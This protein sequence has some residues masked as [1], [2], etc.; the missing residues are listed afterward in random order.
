MDDDTYLPPQRIHFTWQLKKSTFCSLE[1]L[2]KIPTLKHTIIGDKEAP[3]HLSVAKGVSRSCDCVLHGWERDT[4]NSLRNRNN[5]YCHRV[6]SY[7]EA[8]IERRNLALDHN[9]ILL[10]SEKAQIPAT[11]DRSR[12]SSSPEATSSLT[13]CSMKSLVVKN[14]VEEAENMIPPNLPT[15]STTVSLPI[16]ISGTE[17]LHPTSFSP[18]ICIRYSLQVHFQA[19]FRE[20]ANTKVRGKR[21][22]GG[23]HRHSNSHYTAQTDLEV[24]I[25]IIYEGE[26]EDTDENHEINELVFAGEHDETD[27]IVVHNDEQ[28][29]QAI[30]EL[31]P[32]Y[33][34]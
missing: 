17:L 25:Q 13:G 30:E 3:V 33:S 5:N 12:T 28:L 32:G 18:Y 31:L 1:P 14:K 29:G 16:V 10:A 26:G 23:R 4:T 24:P 27:H 11:R 8:Q 22:N 19:S 21:Q 20:D 6:P 34:V 15:L 2:R 7:E 9:M